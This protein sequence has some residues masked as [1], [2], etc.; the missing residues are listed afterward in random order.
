MPAWIILHERVQY[1]TD[2]SR[3]EYNVFYR[4][5]R[6]DGATLALETEPYMALTGNL[7]SNFQTR[8]RAQYANQ[9]CTE[10]ISEIAL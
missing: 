5:L 1:S 10:M 3:Q 6:L 8:E 2:T 9:N 4:T 7:A